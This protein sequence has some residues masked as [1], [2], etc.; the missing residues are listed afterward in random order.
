MIDSFVRMCL[1]T[2]SGAKSCDATLQSAVLALEGAARPLGLNVPRERLCLGRI[3]GM[4][5]FVGIIDG[6]AKRANEWL[7]KKINWAAAKGDLRQHKREMMTL[8]RLKLARFSIAARQRKYA[9]GRDLE[10][11]RFLFP[12]LLAEEDAEERTAVGKLVVTRPSYLLYGGLYE[13]QRLVTDRSPQ[14]RWAMSA[15]MDRHLREKGSGG[16]E[17]ISGEESAFAMMRGKLSPARCC[18]ELKNRLS[19][20]LVEAGALRSA[21]AK[22]AHEF[23]LAL[24]AVIERVGERCAGK[25]IPYSGWP[26]LSTA[27]GTEKSVRD[28]ISAYFSRF[29]TRIDELVAVA[30]G[31][32]CTCSYR[33]CSSA[34]EV[35][36]MMYEHEPISSNPQALP[37][38]IQRLTVAINLKI[39]ALLSKFLNASNALLDSIG[40]VP[41]D[42]ARP[43]SSESLRR[44]DELYAN[45][46]LSTIK[47]KADAIIAMVDALCAI[48]NTAMV[49]MAAVAGSAPQGAGAGTCAWLSDYACGGCGAD[50]PLMYV[51][52]TH[53]SGHYLRSFAGLHERL[54]RVLDEFSRKLNEYAKTRWGR[55]RGAAVPEDVEYNG[56]F[57]IICSVM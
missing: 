57:D 47:E 3:I 46:Q 41:L 25:P 34:S 26:S 42:T 43:H 22:A 7:V 48:V 30:V 38:Q 51:Y 24:L 32:D 36:K 4:D 28:S 23:D 45:G 16:S 6:L 17:I 8:D 10:Q 29:A 1:G 12:A 13:H 20:A 37:Q 33:T 40:A 54:A 21:D 11:L 2:E 15:A 50:I 35:K 55:G 31:G 27:R 18:V 49:Q 14:F 53:Y 56:L 9:S 44:L 5:E 52:G 19:Q 39:R